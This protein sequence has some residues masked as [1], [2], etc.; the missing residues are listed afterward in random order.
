MVVPSPAVTTTTRGLS[1]GVKPMLPSITRVAFTSVVVA[2][3]STWNVPA[4]RDTVCLS[5][6]AEPLTVNTDNEVSV[7]VFALAAEIWIGRMKSTAAASTA[8]RPRTRLSDEL[9]ALPSQES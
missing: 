1:P 6:T 7:P 8:T 9:K 2:S 3:T 5:I 4:G